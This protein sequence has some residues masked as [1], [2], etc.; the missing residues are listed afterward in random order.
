M[1]KKLGTEAGMTFVKMSKLF[2]PKNKKTVTIDFMTV[3]K[4]INIGI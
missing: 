2:A 3:L 1:N 4:F